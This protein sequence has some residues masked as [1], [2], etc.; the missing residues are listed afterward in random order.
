MSRKHPKIGI[1]ERF[2]HWITISEEFYKKTKGGNK[3]KYIKCICTKCNCEK[4]VLTG[5]LHSSKSTKCKECHNPRYFTIYNK[6][7]K[8]EI[9]SI[10]IQD[11][12]DNSIFETIVDTKHLDMIDKLYLS[13]QTD[14]RGNRY[15]WVSS[16]NELDIEYK[17]KKLHQ[18][19]IFLEY[20]YKNQSI[21]ID[22]KNRNK[23][24]NRSINLNVVTPLEN[25]QNASLR[26]DNKSGVRGVSFTNRNQKWAVQI[27]YKNKNNWIGYFD[28]LEEA[29]KARKNAE[30]Q[31]HIYNK[32]IK[33]GEIE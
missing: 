2:G 14:K 6:V 11:T 3:I 1:G 17:P 18:L 7:I 13:V 21:V 25:A 15:V 29:I 31:Y 28:T 9:T 8:D 33:I 30:D 24:D 32:K 20:G 22:H 10:F 5:S 12:R 27:Q 26:R 19:I 23:L 4:D 16:Y